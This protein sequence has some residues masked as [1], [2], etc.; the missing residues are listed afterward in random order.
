MTLAVSPWTGN[1]HEVSGQFADD[2]LDLLM[3]GLAKDMGEDRMRHLCLDA[4]GRNGVISHC[5]GGMSSA[6]GRYLVGSNDD[7]DD[8]NEKS[9]G[10]SIPVLSMCGNVGNGHAA[11]HRNGTFNCRFGS[12]FKADFHMGMC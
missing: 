9:T 11:D 1:S 12:K 6:K 2:H 5:L 7:T 10:C 3:G 4:F 8:A